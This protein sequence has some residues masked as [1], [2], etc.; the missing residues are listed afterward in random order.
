MRLS[1]SAC[2]PSNNKCLTHQSNHFEADFTEFQSVDAVSN[3]PFPQ[4]A[5]GAADP[6][7]DG[8]NPIKN[9]QL[10]RVGRLVSASR[11]C[12]TCVQ[13]RPQLSEDQNPS[14]IP[15][16]ISLISLV[17]AAVPLVLHSSEPISER[18]AMISETPGDTS[19]TG[20]ASFS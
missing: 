5:E 13:I 2:D 16:L 1:C 17:P 15:G 14:P 11:R 6:S 4:T 19:T 9:A 8:R 7:S 10:Q 3:H 18:Y 12:Q 20:T